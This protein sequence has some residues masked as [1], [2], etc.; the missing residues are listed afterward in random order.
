MYR[1]RVAAIGSDE[2]LV[3]LAQYE[4]AELDRGVGIDWPAI[5]LEFYG[6]SVRAEQSNLALTG[7]ILDWTRK[8]T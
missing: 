1:L 5:Y 3:G 4:I 7:E 8:L 2:G 6:L